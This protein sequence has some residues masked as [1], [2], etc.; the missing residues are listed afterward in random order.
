M[1]RIY[2]PQDLMEAQ[3][4]VGMLESEGIEAHVAGRDLVGAVGEL[5]A[6]GL[7]ALL[8]EQDQAER[9]ISL[10]REYNAAL[11]VPGDEPEYLPGVLLC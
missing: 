1:Q 10:I 11:P 5:P 8:V 2:E 4:L 7:L 3:M 6:L 9:A